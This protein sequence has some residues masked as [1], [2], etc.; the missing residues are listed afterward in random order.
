MDLAQ[1]NERPRRPAGVGESRIRQ[2]R[3]DQPPKIR[4]A[5]LAA[6]RLYR[7]GMGQSLAAEARFDVV[8]TT[9]DLDG[10]LALGARA[11][12]DVFLVDMGMADG[13]RII[14]TLAAELP[15]VGVVAFALDE[16]EDDVLACAEAGIVGYVPRE[17][18][19]SELISVVESAASSEFICSPKIAAKL[20]R[21]LHAQAHLPDRLDTG[22]LTNRERQVWQLIAHGLA[23]KEIATRLGTSVATAKNHVHNLLQKLN[24]SSRTEAAA[25][26]HQTSQA[27]STQPVTTTP[28][29]KRSA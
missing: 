18:A 2:A 6:V 29:R 7:E 21:R 14:E 25:A 16:V 24:S 11:K 19:L 28:D 22:L 4:I 9:S 10:A 23:N 26:Y 15:S 1:L 27:L 17:A 8:G 3:M 13:L 20:L 12:L 5:V